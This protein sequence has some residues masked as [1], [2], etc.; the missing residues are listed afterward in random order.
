MSV[1]T[2]EKI[3]SL[4][5][6]GLQLL[7]QS[8]VALCV[9]LT[10]SIAQ[11]DLASFFGSKANP[12]Q[13]ASGAE[14]RPGGR[15]GNFPARGGPGGPVHGGRHHHHRHHHHHHH[16]HRPGHYPARRPVHYP[17]RGPVH[18][19]RPVVAA[20][21]RAVVVAPIRPIPAVRPWYWGSVVAGVTIGTIVVVSTVG[22]VPPAPSP[23][24]CW[25]WTS[26]DKMR[27]Y[28]SYCT[29]PPAPM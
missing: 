4:V 15:P 29:A 20:P 19:R 28:W 1:G 18:G 24:L 25:Y 7:K 9:F 5:S 6:G 23:E 17:A 10:L 8:V 16:H 3:G 12:F 14:A 27:G 26:A 11:I 21:R 2:N 13:F 22:A